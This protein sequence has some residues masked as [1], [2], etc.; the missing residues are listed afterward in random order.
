MTTVAHIDKIA[1]AFQVGH[2]GALLREQWTRGG[3]CAK[4]KKA[5]EEDD[6]LNFDCFLAMAADWVSS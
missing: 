1:F 6:I 5:C 2:A 3:H 4:A